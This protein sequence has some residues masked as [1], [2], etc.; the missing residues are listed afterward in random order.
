MLTHSPLA[1][2]VDL[3]GTKVE[4][5]LVDTDGKIVATGRSTTGPQKGAEQILR[6]ILACIRETC[7]P[8]SCS[9]P[10][11]VGL[12]VAGQVDTVTGIVS[13]APNLGWEKVPLGSMVQEALH[14]PVV[15]TNDVQA[16]T[17]GEW[18][19][20]AAKGVEDMVCVFV[21]TGVGGGIVSGGRMLAGCSGSAGEL[22]H[23]TI[24]MR[25]PSCR[26]GNRGCLEALA[27]GWAIAR[28][29][30]LA[31]ARNREAGR[32]LLAGVDGDAGALTAAHVG[33][34]AHAGDHLAQRLVAQ[35]GEA[36]IAGVASVVNVMN[37]CLVVIGGGVIE[38]LPELVEQVEEGVRRR[39]LPTPAARVRIAKASLGRYAGVVGAA[40]LA[41]IRFGGGRENGRA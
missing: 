24:D 26:C 31:V 38:G 35:T 25:G 28:R 39:A 27:G 5:A 41:R 13:Y 22:G 10:V 2:G 36:L 16:A 18:L 1:I 37:P 8:F 7:T 20:G 14:L 4:T 19:H 11:G 15:V 21:G 9:Q 6:D 23:I 29:A 3:G 30:R 33:E 34:A 40:A 12:G 17:W 32:T